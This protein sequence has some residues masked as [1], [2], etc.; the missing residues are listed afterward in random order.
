MLDVVW[1]TCCMVWFIVDVVWFTFGMVWFTFGMVW[2][3]LDVVWFICGMVWFIFG[4]FFE[5]RVYLVWHIFPTAAR[6][7]FL[8]RAVWYTF[9]GELVYFG[10]VRA[11]SR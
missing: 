8:I 2:F 4:R 11:L 6:S 9:S 10:H 5:R 3:M 1:F 7:V